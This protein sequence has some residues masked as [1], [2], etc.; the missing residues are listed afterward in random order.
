MAEVWRVTLQ[1][2]PAANRCAC[3]KLRSAAGRSRGRQYC[4]T[5][6]VDRAEEM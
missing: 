1:G 2:N 3:Q 4:A 6:F 5:V